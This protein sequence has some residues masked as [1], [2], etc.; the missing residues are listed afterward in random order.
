MLWS[1]DGPVVAVILHISYD[2]CAL[3]FSGLFEMLMSGCLER[4]TGGM[5][6]TRASRVFRG[7]I[8]ANPA[9]SLVPCQGLG[10]EEG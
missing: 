3:P 5:V 6:G 8:A 2:K 7:C 4:R 10:F 1:G 9:F